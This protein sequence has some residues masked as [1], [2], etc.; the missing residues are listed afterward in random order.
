MAAL[1]FISIWY[2]LPKHRWSLTFKTGSSNSCKRSKVFSGKSKV[3]FG[4]MNLIFTCKM[5]ITKTRNKTELKAL[6]STMIL[7][8]LLWYFFLGNFLHP[9]L[10][11]TPNTSTY[12]ILSKQIL[13]WTLDRTNSSSVNRGHSLT[14]HKIMACLLV[15]LVMNRYPL[16]SFWILFSLQIFSR[17]LLF[18][19]PFP[20]KSPDPLYCLHT[21]LR[22]LN[23]TSYSSPDC[24]GQ[25]S[26]PTKCENQCYWMIQ[27]I[28]CNP[29]SGSREIKLRVN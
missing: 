24:L 19:R 18:Q 17:C 16:H 6:I 12:I 28:V 20:I 15:V 7:L 26:S 8:F 25:S 22:V 11:P 21:E 4:F 23:G 2:Y 5:W 29:F 9:K 27:E 10:L 3:F 14:W 13:V 1:S